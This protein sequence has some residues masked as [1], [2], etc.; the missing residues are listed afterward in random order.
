MK[1]LGVFRMRALL[2][3]SALL[4]LCTVVTAQA[5]IFVD[6]GQRLGRASSR[7]VSLG[8]L[9][10]DGDL[11]AFV[12]NH[13]WD[14]NEVWLND[15]TGFFT[16][17][18]PSPNISWSYGAGLGDFD[19]DG[20]LDVFIPR[21][22]L[23]DNA[24]QVW[25]ND[26]TG[27]FFDS[28]QRLGQWESYEV[29]VGD[30][31]GDG[32]L[33]AFTAGF[34]D[35]SCVWLNNGTGI[36]IDSGQR[37]SGSPSYDVALGDFDGDGD[38]DAFIVN[39]GYLPN[40]VWLNDGTGWFTDSGQR[41]GNLDS[42]RVALGDID[43]DGDLD[44]LVA[45][46]G[47]PNELWLN[48]GSGTF[49]DSGQ[50]LGGFRNT[51]GVALADVELDGDLD[52]LIGN[53]DGSGNELWLNDGLGQFTDSGQTLGGCIV[54]EITLGDLDGD[55][56]L[57]VFIAN[58]L[59]QANMVWLN[60]TNPI[61]PNDPPVVYVGGPYS[62][63]EGDSIMV[64][65]SGSDPNGD[66][67]TFAWDLDNDGSFETSGQSVA[68]SAAD[69]DGPSGHIIAVQVTDSGGLSA[70]EET[71]VEVL[72]VAPM[73]G[74]ITAPT[75]PVMVGAVID[76]TAD[77]TDPGTADT[78][79]A[80]WDWGDGAVGPGTVAQGAGYGSVTGSHV[81]TEPGVNTIKLTVTDDD[82][83][84]GESVYQYVVV[85]DPDGGFV[86][87]G[88][89]IDSPPGAYA[90]NPALVG[91]A[92][93]GFVSKYKRGATVPSGNTEFIFHAADL[94][95]HSASYQW[96]VVTGSTYAKY[97]GAGTINGGLAPNDSEYK[98]MLWAGDAEADTFRIKIWYE[99]GDTEYV[100]YDN[101]FDQEIGSGSIIIHTK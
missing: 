24:E 65:A 73:V 81:Y 27:T 67:I 84:W 56:D 79:T 14:L 8:D 39:Y 21:A 52:A 57:D 42:M 12:A 101:G 100:V 69:L 29:D 97:K 30:V 19:D 90:A 41:L 22:T 54:R 58:D 68:F 87:G 37:I 16:D 9:D 50:R 55:N 32:D 47:Q 3:G 62:V 43:G 78:H 72:N 10:Q 88:G 75:D 18:S 2:A 71:I 82:N 91:K 83:G 60:G 77:F 17:N 92:T 33:D 38:L 1:Y 46:Q 94:N 49:T 61:P 96:L 44:A 51:H 5:V 93:F 34:R 36:F 40:E 64:S 85:Y 31:D 6:S 7:S 63:Y 45:N 15:G 86:T 20:D 25:L 26:G 74:A 59:H 4:L 76:T 28:G 11:D 80:L 35:P 13:E 70:T 89:W 48:D 95:F 99:V 98:F 23:S 53:Y 66:P